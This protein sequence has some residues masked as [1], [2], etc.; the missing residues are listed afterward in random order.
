[1]KKLSN[2]VKRRL[3]AFDSVNDTVLILV[4]LL[5]IYPFLYVFFIASSD[6]TYLTKGE[7][8]FFPK[9]FNLEA[10]KYVLSNPKFDIFTGMRNSFI[11]TIL[12]TFIAVLFTYFTAYALSRPRLR[13]RYFIMALFVI[14]WVFEAGIIPQYI[15]YSNLGFID[16]IWVMIIPGAINVQFLLI[17]KAFLDGLP[18][19]LEEAAF[20]DGATDFQSLQRV[21]LPISK[22]ILATIALFNAVSIWNQYLVPQMFLKSDNLKT[23]QQILKSVVI[24]SSNSGTVFNNV[25]RNGYTLNQ[26]NMKAAAI[27]IAMAPIVCVY[28]FVQKYFKKG[29]LIGSVKG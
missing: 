7:V 14:T 19:E 28:P 1:M 25:I 2:K 27:F 4:A 11:Y 17:T 5:C 3:T 20:I 12:G 22:P 23:I 8:N 13:Q 18:A 16:N 29:I 10:F 21:F 26:N 9:G 6:G 15:I 24:T